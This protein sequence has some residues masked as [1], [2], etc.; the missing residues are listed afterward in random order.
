MKLNLEKTRA[1]IENK[2]AERRWDIAYQTLLDWGI[3][4]EGANK[5]HSTKE[6]EEHNG[7]RPL[8]PSINRPTAEISKY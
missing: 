6:Q 5:N 1:F 2:E 4:K 7:N 8:R 3:E